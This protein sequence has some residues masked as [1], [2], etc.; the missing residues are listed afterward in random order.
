MLVIASNGFIN[1][2]TNNANTNGFSSSITAHHSA[3][4][5]DLFDTT[6]QKK[7]IIFN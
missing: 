6:K 1:C 5:F 2:L 4:H 3:A 7:T